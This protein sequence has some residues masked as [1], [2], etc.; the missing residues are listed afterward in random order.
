MR[1]RWVA[2]LAAALVVSTA[3]PA[4]ARPAAM[5]DVSLAWGSGG[6]IIASGGT[7]QID[8]T[9]TTEVQCSD[10][11]ALQTVTLSGEATGT[12]IFD[13]RLMTGAIE[14]TG[15]GITQ[16]VMGACGET[17]A[18]AA[19]GVL[20]VT[21]DGR[22]SVVRERVGGA[23]VIERSGTVLVTGLGLVDVESQAVVTRTITK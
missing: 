16:T 4:F 2:G 14:I 18:E 9:V 12:V 7:V 11:N 19:L 23:R 10:G 6:T 17:F 5:D 22:G 8:A 15:E 13:Q 1:R 21:F 3:A 20:T